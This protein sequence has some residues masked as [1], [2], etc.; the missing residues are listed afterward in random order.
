LI[1]SNNKKNAQLPSGIENI[2]AVYRNGIGQP[3]NVLTEQISLLQS[4]PLGVKSVINPLAASGG[5][6]KENRDQARESAPLAVMVLDRLVS[7]RDYADFTRTFAGIAKADAQRLS[8]GRRQL[9]HLTIAGIDDIVIDPDSDLYQNLLLALRKLGDPCLPVQV[10]LRELLVLTMSAKVRLEADYQWDPVVEQIRAAVLATFSFQHRSFGQPALLSEAI[11]LIQN[12][13]GVAYVDV[14]AFGGVPE[15]T[16]DADGTR[17][18]LT[19]DELADSISSIVNPNGAG[20][21]SGSG[22]RVRRSGLVLVVMANRG[23][24]DNGGIRPAQLAIFTSV[25]PDMLILNQII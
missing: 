1:F 19:L 25:V 8:D 2:H 9:I 15:K 10:D 24:V 21:T 4:R 7:L 16:T 3:G 12:I 22:R 6:D 18:L 20:S 14:D 13:P 23:A 5:A 11:A 17:R